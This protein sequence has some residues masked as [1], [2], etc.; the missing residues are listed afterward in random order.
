MLHS[1]NSYHQEHPQ[2]HYLVYV[3]SW[4]PRRL[5]PFN[6]VEIRVAAG[7]SHRQPGS[8]MTCEYRYNLWCVSVGINIVY[9]IDDL[10][11][12]VSEQFNFCELL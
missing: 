10:W 6:A 3:E 5:N 11:S 12:I 7:I 8:F 9:L 1:S 4:F 2:A